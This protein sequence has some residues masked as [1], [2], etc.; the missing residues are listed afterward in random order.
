[1]KK[2]PLLAVAALALLV[3]GPA[4]AAQTYKLDKNHSEV[5][6]QIRHLVS[7]VRGRFTDYDGTIQ[8]DT[9][10]PEKSTVELRIKAASIDTGVP[11]RDKHLRSPDFFDVEKHPEIVF[12][13]KSI[14]KL[15]D[16]RYEV[17]GTL[18]MRGVQKEVPV[19]VTLL[20][21]MPD[22]GGATRAGFEATTTINRKDFGVAWNRAVEAGGVILGDDVAVT[23]TLE[24]IAPPATPAP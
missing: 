23:V 10:N 19:T 11:D 8:M 2:K 6:F 9:Q 17:L 15:A 18:D 24:A 14:K 13:S 21:S 22:R 12:K 16:D 1:M 7:K 20:G 5:S 3:A 4:I